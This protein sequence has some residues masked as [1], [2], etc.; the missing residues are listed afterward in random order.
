MRIGCKDSLS[1][2]KSLRRPEYITKGVNISSYTEEFQHT[3]FGA[4]SK[5]LKQ[6]GTISPQGKGEGEFLLK[7]FDAVIMNPPFSDREKMPPYMREKLKRNTDLT[8]IS[9][10]Q[11]NLWGYFLALGNFLLKPGGKIGAVIPV[12]I[13]R[14]KATENIRE[15]L[16]KN[17][18]IDYII[19]PIGDLAFSEGSAFKDVLFIARNQ[20]P[21]KTDKTK[22][23]LLKQSIRDLQFEKVESVLSRILKN[24]KSDYVDSDLE[25][26]EV[27]QED[28]FRHKENLMYFLWASSI[29]TLENSIEFLHLLDSDKLIK[30]KDDWTQEGFH[31]S[32]AGLSELTFITRNIDESRIKRAFYILKSDNSDKI[33]FEIKDSNQTYEVLKSKTK[34]A[35]RTIT[36]VNTMDVCKIHDYIILDNFPGFKQ[37]MDL[38]FSKWEKKNEFSWELVRDKAKNKDVYLA[39]SRRFNLYSPNTSLVAFY[40][41]NKFVPPDTL[42]IFTKFNKEDSK[43]ICLFLNSII[44]LIQMFANKEETTGQYGT[45]RGT[46]LA[47]FNVFDITKLSNKDKELLH[48]TFKKIKGSKFPSIKDQLSKRFPDR[49]ELD[50]AVLTVLGFSKKQINEWL[51]KI[52]DG[53]LLELNS[54]QVTG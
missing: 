23:I 51:P 15:F 24:R 27:T 33:K 52:Y 30:I 7:P 49:I 22:I 10:N 42:K 48:T 36:G 31:A 5:K 1:L 25:I 2:A 39:F 16:I 32:P 11:V 29:N 9:G 46:D 28:L 37:I 26:F 40:S 4:I 14:G 12:N 18:C 6:E 47:L 13:A 35:L 45:I 53:L 34:P 41:E 21:Q 54:I 44:N 19:K 43:I 50:T 3:L 20:K 38:D 8:N 17:Y